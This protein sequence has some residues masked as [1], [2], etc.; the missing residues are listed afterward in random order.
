MKEPIVADSTCLIG[1]ER[2]GRLN[3][4]PELFEPVFIP[5]EVANE[6]GVSFSWLKIETP[7]NFALVNALKL[8]VDDGEAEAIALALEK[9]CK[10]ILDDKQARFVAKKLGLEIVGT[11]GMFV[12]AKQNNLIDSLKTVLDDLENNGFRMSE[13]L[14]AA[15][16]KIVGE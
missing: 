8:S 11:I 4:L 7:S 12:A 1:L 15:A 5:N 3:V 13:N 16:L 6:F 14:K 9:N 2:I 10:V